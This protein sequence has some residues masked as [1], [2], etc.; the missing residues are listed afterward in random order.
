MLVFRN[1]APN[2]RRPFCCHGN[3][4]GSVSLCC[5]CSDWRGGSVPLNK[6][7]FYSHVCVREMITPLSLRQT[8]PDLRWQNW[9]KL[10]MSRNTRTR[11]RE[12]ELDQ[13]GRM[14]SFIYYI[15]RIQYATS[16]KTLA[17]SK[18]LN[19]PIYHTTRT[20][21]S[22]SYCRVA[23]FKN[24]IAVIILDMLSVETNLGKKSGLTSQHYDSFDPWYYLCIKI[25]SHFACYS[26]LYNLDWEKTFC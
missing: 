18:I 21:N 9:L 4:F 16:E 1:R 11:S 13:N 7:D 2:T 17:I 15:L 26:D 10:S 5:M 23:K 25:L 24:A 12:D 20:Q 3:W 14:F 22:G 8:L 6:R 19:Q